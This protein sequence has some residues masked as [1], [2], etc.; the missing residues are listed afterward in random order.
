M[1]NQPYEYHEAQ[2][3]IEEYRALYR[4]EHGLIQAHDASIERGE[5]PLDEHSAIRAERINQAFTASITD[6]TPN[7]R[8]YRE[9]TTSR[10]EQARRKYWGGVR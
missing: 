4:L 9:G 1:N 2:F 7:E 6:E 5:R 8:E 3:S 10:A